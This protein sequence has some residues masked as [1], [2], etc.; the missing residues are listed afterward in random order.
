MDEAAARRVLL[1][2]AIE[3]TDGDGRLLPPA[4][5]EQ[6]DMRSR[7]DALHHGRAIMGADEFV[8]LRAQRV[9]GAVAVRHPWLAALQEPRP[10][11]AWLEWL[12][13][14]VA[15]VV[16]VA[17][18]AIG[19]PHRVD[20]VSLPLLG[21]VVWNVVVYLLLL[22]GAVWPRRK[23]DGSK[24]RH[25]WLAHVGRWN[26][27]V[28]RSRRG[29]A[30]M[31]AAANFQLEW[32]RAS[33]ALHV[34]R[35]KR[36]LHLS[37]AAW[38]LGVILSLLV[39]GLVVE[40][41]VGWEST[42]LGPQQVYAILSV[43]RLPA[44]L[45]LPFDTF[46]VFDVAQ[47]RFSDG[48]GA[49]VGAPWVWMYASL[50]VTVVVLPR[51]L[52]ATYAAWREERLG[53]AFAFD[54]H[55]PYFERVLSLL[56][57]TRVQLGLL[58]HRQADRDKLLRVIAPHPDMLPVL[59][60]SLAGDVM[61]LV[62]VPLV[63]SLPPL[64]AQPPAPAGW[65]SRLRSALKFRPQ[66][67]E[68]AADP[69]LVHARDECDLILH[70]AGRAGD[71]E[72]AAALLQWLGKPV[73]HIDMGGG[74]GL[75]FE[76]FARCWVLDGVFL[77]AVSQALPPPRREGFG[78]IARAWQ[79]RNDEQL[80][81]SMLAV[82]DHLLFAARQVEELQAGALSVK[83]LL[84][85]QREAQTGARQA[86]M[87]RIARRLEESAASCFARLRHIHRV[88]DAAA[89]ALEHKLEERFVVQQPVDAPQAGMAGAATGAAM[90]ASVDLL[91]GGLT[92]GAAAA[93]GA[94]VGGGAGYI[95]AAWRNRSSPTGATSV[96]LSDEMLEALLEAALLR[97]VAIIHWARGWPQVEARWKDEVTS[98]VRTE[99]ALL[100]GYWAAARTQPAERLVQALAQELGR[101]AGAVLTHIYPQS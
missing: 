50:L 63:Q 77:A 86:A 31:R 58:A 15:L 27:P 21:I 55:S 30:A 8:H 51:L 2:Q 35:V 56:A 60:S 61:G 95:A 83:S 97:Y 79:A 101:I 10:W 45:V 91:A 19:N 36:V 11:Q 26:G 100:V 69:A 16:G 74:R 42:F 57:S 93:L 47:L 33:Q 32:F 1:A 37:A 94:L 85:A 53:R 4:E 3:T 98:C 73:V 22:I 14:I 67:V 28:P 70:V 81:R 52:L 75:R 62:P 72:E 18:D 40:Y 66:P 48:G 39:R 9:L 29:D 54:A 84:P 82:A 65:M 38:A 20:L 89:D 41:R 64:H 5:R 25:S 23:D 99:R 88:D 34:E 46:T 71:V 44:L 12:V 92:L 24:P 78:H 80:H 49:P 96:Q 43:L 17:T 76:D 87:E 90:G 6:V 7:Q 68:P 59:V 13:P